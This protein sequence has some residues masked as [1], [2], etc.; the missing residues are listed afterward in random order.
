MNDFWHKKKWNEGNSHDAFK[1][2]CCNW[3]LL[4]LRTFHINDASAP[5]LLKKFLE[6]KKG[7]ILT[8]EYFHNFITNKILE[9][10]KQSFPVLTIEVF[11]PLFKAYTIW[12][13]SVSQPFKRSSSKELNMSVK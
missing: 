9:K 5:L 11:F 1:H 10:A 4:L 12:P 13:L 2:E 8:D 6:P 7:S 3:M